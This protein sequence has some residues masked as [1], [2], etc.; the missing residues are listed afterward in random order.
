MEKVEDMPVEVQEAVFDTVLQENANYKEQQREIEK[1][2][3]EAKGWDPPEP[4]PPA[5]AFENVE[6]SG[7]FGLYFN[8]DVAGLSFLE[9]L[10]KGL[11]SRGGVSDN[12]MGRVLSGEDEDFNMSSFLAFTV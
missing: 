7:T 11:S 4:K 12:G 3:A 5:L 2:E 8:S 1:L 6:P 10:N 9:S